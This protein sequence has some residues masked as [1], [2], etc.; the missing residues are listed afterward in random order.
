MCQIRGCGREEVSKSV[1]GAGRVR[2]GRLA[3]VTSLYLLN[4]HAGSG[5]ESDLAPRTLNRC[6]NMGPGMKMLNQSQSTSWSREG[7]SMP[8]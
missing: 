4:G 1:T 7:M 8:A 6:T 3:R 2:K 5:R